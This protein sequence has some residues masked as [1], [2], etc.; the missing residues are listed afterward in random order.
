MVSVKTEGKNILFEAQGLHKLWSFKSKLEIPKEHILNAY[1]NDDELSGWKGWRAPGTSVPY[2]ITAGT[3][4]L[5]GNRIFWD[6]VNKENT[7][8]ISLKDEEYQKLIIE[9]ENPEEAIKL[10]KGKQ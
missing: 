6:V 4:H 9:V 2:L 1:Q 8:I 5:S 3:F 10:L 7:I